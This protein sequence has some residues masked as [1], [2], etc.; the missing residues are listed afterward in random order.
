VDAREAAGSHGR[1]HPDNPQEQVKSH[2][3]R[4]GRGATL[5]P[6]RV[7][8]L[9]LEDDDQ[10]AAEVTRGLR[11]AGF[12]VDGAG[13]LT[14]A[15]EKVAVNRYDC[16]VLDRALPDGDGLQLMRD[17]R[18]RGGRVPVLM[19]TARDSVD[20]RVAGFASGADDHLGKPF[21]LAELTARVNAL[22]R[23][24]ERPRPVHTTVGDVR[25]DR[26]LR[27]V[28]RADVLIPLTAKEFA[29]LE[30]LAGEPDRVVT[31]TSLIECCWDEM[32]EP[33]SNVVDA[34]IAQLRR[35]LGPPPVI[36]TV[37]GAGFRLTAGG[38]PR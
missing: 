12:A 27:R 30:A 5:Y 35:K 24:A 28:T 8:V 1:D 6:S 26:A 32:A 3:T 20:D 22:C 10:L 36:V 11:A 33:M 13:S 9:V 23:R 19:M 25:I 7:R 15:Q 18:A 21:A 14:E 34:V 31:R 29:V 4:R 17:H 37:R 16:L 2:R 38:E